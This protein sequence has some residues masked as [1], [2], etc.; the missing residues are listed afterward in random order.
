MAGGAW[1]ATVRGTA[2]SGHSLVTKQQEIIF[3][4]T[5]W[6]GVEQ[7][8]Q[9]VGRRG[10]RGRLREAATDTWW[11]EARGGTKH[12]TVHRRALPGN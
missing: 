11:I 3:V 10:F 8:G 12:S 4:V 2:R 9:V 1:R 7:V 6:L 5:A